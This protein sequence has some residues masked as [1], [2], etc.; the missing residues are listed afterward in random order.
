MPWSCVSNVCT[1][2]E[3][4]IL[5]EGRNASV[6]KESILQLASVIQM[7]AFKKMWTLEGVD[8][9]KEYE[10]NEKK[11]SQNAKKPTYMAIGKRVRE[12]KQAIGKNSDDPLCER[13]AEC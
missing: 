11:S 10:K 2:T 7:R 1:S 3:L 6:T 9:E 12:Y 5:R 8:A 4:A 13:P